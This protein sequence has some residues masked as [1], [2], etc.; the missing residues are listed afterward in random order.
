MRDRSSLAVIFGIL[1]IILLTAVFCITQLEIVPSARWEGPSREVRANRYFAL[2]NWLAESG[3]PARILSRATVDTILAGPEKTIFAEVSQLSWTDS[4]R[5]IPWLREGGQLVIVLDA[6]I[7]LQLEDFIQSLGIKAINLYNDD[8]EDDDE[9]PAD[10]SADN[11]ETSAEAQPEQPSEPE[12]LTER[13]PDFDTECS[14]R[15]TEKKP[16]VD[17]ILVMNEQDKTR[18][19]KLETGKG[20]IIFTGEANFLHNYNLRKKENV[21]LAGE[22][23]LAGRSGDEDG[24]LL[25]RGLGGDRH[26]F[27]NL[28]ERGNPWALAASLVLLIAAGFWMVIPSFGRYRPAPEKPGKPLR[29]RF[30]AEVRFLKKYQA[31]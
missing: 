19:V 21:N 27:G 12:A 11:A 25:I 24:V 8:D 29:E 23:F 7:G 4:G 15:I 30:L 22:I 18:L 1:G 20:W 6:P 16:G 9:E 31:L 2:D 28:V 26:F 14:F 10:T 13:L 5:I 17:R 3:R